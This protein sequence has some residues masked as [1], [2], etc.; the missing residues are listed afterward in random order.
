MIFKG[1]QRFS[2]PFHFFWNRAPSICG[3]QIGYKQFYVIVT[4]STL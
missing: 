1:I 2:A 4:V 3:N